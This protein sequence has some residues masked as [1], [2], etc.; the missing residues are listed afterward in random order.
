V[1]LA[2]YILIT[3][4]RLYRWILSPAK[5]AL[6]G[7]S[8]QCRFH[9]SCSAY[10]LEALQTHGCWKGTWLALKRLARCHPWGAFGADPVPPKHSVRTADCH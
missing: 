3:A 8:G 9:P 6:F 10:A 5:D 4:V 7:P 2:Q 1:R